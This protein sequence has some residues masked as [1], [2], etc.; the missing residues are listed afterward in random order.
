MIKWLDRGLMEKVGRENIMSGISTVSIGVEYKA[1]FIGHV[2]IGPIL[3]ILVILSIGI[4][5]HIDRLEVV[6]SFPLEVLSNGLGD[7]VEIFA[8]SQNIPE[9]LQSVRGVILNSLGV[10]PPE[11]NDVL[12]VHFSTAI[13]SDCRTQSI[14]LGKRLRVSDQGIGPHFI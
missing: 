6:R 3:T 4:G 1:I 14:G 2:G 7:L 12:L 13:L 10:S 9:N 5:L 8:M 11:S